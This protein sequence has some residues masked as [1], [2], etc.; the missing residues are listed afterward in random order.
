[1]SLQDYGALK[2]EEET[3]G[4][5]VSSTATLVLAGALDIYTAE[6][7]RASWLASVAQSEK[8]IWLDLGGVESCDAAGLQVLL[9]FEKSSRDAGKSFEIVAVSPV[10]SQLAAAF[11]ICWQQ[12]VRPDPEPKAAQTDDNSIAEKETESKA[13]TLHDHA[14][15]C[16]FYA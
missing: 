8:Q 13:G 4:E 3:P 5:D 15:K 12:R 9:A 2:V 16:G 1:M 6:Q 14:E 10:L 11:G 7:V